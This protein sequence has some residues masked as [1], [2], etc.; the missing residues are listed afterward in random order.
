MLIT[1]DNK[2]LKN[3]SDENLSSPSEMKLD[4]ERYIEDPHKVYCHQD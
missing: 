2:K 1:G 4:V 3:E